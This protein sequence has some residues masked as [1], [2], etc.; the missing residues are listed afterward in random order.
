[1]NDHCSNVF[2]NLT[3]GWGCLLMAFMLLIVVWAV[4]FAVKLVGVL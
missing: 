1:M 2:Q 4:A 3:C